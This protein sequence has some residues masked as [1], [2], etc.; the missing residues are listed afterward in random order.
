M[1]WEI[2]PEQW[3]MIGI[4]AKGLKYLFS[5]ATAATQFM[6]FIKWL[7]GKKD[8]KHNNNTVPKWYN[9]K[10]RIGRIGRKKGS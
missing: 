4:A 2:T 7:K 5:V 6:N 3:V 10:F 8:E 9:G 1:K